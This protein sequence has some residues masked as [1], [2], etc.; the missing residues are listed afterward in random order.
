MMTF[1]H[2][3]FYLFL[4]ISVVKRINEGREPKTT[5]QIKSDKISIIYPEI[6]ISRLR[7]VDRNTHTALF[8]REKQS[9]QGRSAPCR[10]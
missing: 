2:I 1:E 3:L 7:L 8:V 10:R 5:C 6:L 4:F 9:K